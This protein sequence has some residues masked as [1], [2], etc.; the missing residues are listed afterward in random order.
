MIVN[1]TYRNGAGQG[2][3]DVICLAA[4]CQRFFHIVA[5]L[6]DEI[7]AAL[8]CNWG[9]CRIVCI[10]EYTQAGDIPP[11]M[12]TEEEE[13][14][15]EDKSVSPAPRE[16]YA[17]LDLLGLREESAHGDHTAWSEFCAISDNCTGHVPRQISDADGHVCRRLLRPHYPTRTDWMVCNW[18]K[19]QYVQAQAIADLCGRPNAMQPFLHGCPVKLWHVVLSQIC[20]SSEGCITMPDNSNGDLHRGPWAGDIF[21]ITTLERL[22]SEEKARFEDVS[23]RVVHDLTEVFRSEYGTGDAKKWPVRGES[24]RTVAKRTS[25]SS[26]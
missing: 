6:L 4:T 7:R 12:L 24:A 2:A 21:T 10:G 26:W 17:F 9:Q 22:S 8:S 5:P 18:S 20:W 16:K 19:F 23:V 25:N 1:E 15:I 11:G 13:Q 3:L 14:E